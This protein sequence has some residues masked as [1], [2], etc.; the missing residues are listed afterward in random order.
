M[1][2]IKIYNEL[3][4]RAQHDD[5]FKNNY[6]NTYYE[7]HH[8]IP[9]CKKGTDIKH[10]RV[11]LTSREHFIAHWLLT[12]IYKNDIRLIYAFNCFCQ[13]ASRKNKRG[14]SKNYKYAKQKFIYILKTNDEWKKKISDTTKK[15]IWLKND[16]INK[17]IRV[18]SD[19]IDE[20][21]KIGYEK[22]RI[23]FKRTAPTVETRQKMRNSAV[24]RCISDKHRKSNSE[25]CKNTIWVTNG[26]KDKMIKQHL[27]IPI[28]FFKGRKKF[29]RKQ[30]TARPRKNIVH[31]HRYYINN[32]IKIIRTSEHKLD[33][34]LNNGWI[35]G[36]VIKN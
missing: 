31:K 29:N 2:Y 3:I 24:G 5:R 7:N 25:N 35:K 28:G 34:Y 8:I 16:C 13:D 23:I 20:Y 11:L 32:G 1:N 36:K 4:Y 14:L 27:E 15:L 22:G 12:K 10:N 19:L 18:N 6:K 33:Y 9:K 26:I 21:E 30:P 17:C